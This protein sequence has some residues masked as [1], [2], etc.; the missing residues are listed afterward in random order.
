MRAGALK[1][2]RSFAIEYDISGANPATLLKTLQQDWGYLVDTLQVTAHPRYLYHEGKPVVSVWGIGLNDSKHPPSDIP[3]ALE[4]IDWFRST[5]KVTY[6]GG[7]PADWRTF[8][9]DALADP[10]GAGVYQPMG[11]LQPVTL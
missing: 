6:I 1:Y 2:G 9:N 4:L 8:S 11:G 10:A 3:A 7:T 5:A